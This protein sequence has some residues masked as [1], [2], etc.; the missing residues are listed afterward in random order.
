M[1]FVMKKRQLEL[2]MALIMILILSVYARSLGDIAISVMEVKRSRVVVIDPGHGGF[3]PGK[4]GINQILEKDI[5]LSI[6]LKLKNLL[7]QEGIFVIMTREEDVGLY[8]ET[9][10]N[11]K[12]SDMEKRCDIIDES[13]CDLAVSIHQNSFSSA[14]VS[15]PQVF[16]FETSAEGKELATIIQRQLIDILKPK[17]ERVEKAN[18]NYYM[19]KKVKVPSVI[20]ECGFLTNSEEAMLLTEDHYQEKIAL[21]I[22]NGILEYFKE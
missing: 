7:E 18:N 20:V 3:D 14:S 15:G 12:L 9:D 4:V 1:S 6:A 19:L 2:A 16:Y 11:K 10:S 8:K 13:N 22:K 21:A 17:K 5:N